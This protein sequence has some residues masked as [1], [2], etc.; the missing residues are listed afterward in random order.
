MTANFK[1]NQSGSKQKRLWFQ[2]L[3]G[4]LILVMLGV[5]L[6][7][8]IV[9]GLVTYSQSQPRLKAD[10]QDE[11]TRVSEIQRMAIE[12][13]LSGI[14]ENVR[15]VA[16]TERVRSM[17][18]QRAQSAVDGYAIDWPFYEGIYVLGPDGITIA[19]SKQTVLDLST[20]EYF[21]KAMQGEANISQPVISRV[22]GKMIVSV[23]VPVVQDGEIVGVAAGA[24]PIS[25]I[26]EL[27]QSSWVG[28]TGDA[29]LVNDQ[30]Y[31]ITPSRF[32]DQMIEEGLVD[33]DTMAISADVQ[34]EASFAD[35][36]EGAGEYVNFRGN[37][38]IGAYSRIESRGWG[39]I[40]EQDVS[41]ALVTANFIRNVLLVGGVI[42]AVIVAIIGI[43][44]A[45]Q[46]AN[47]I[48]A[49]TRTAQELSLGHI[50]Q[51]VKYRSK[52]EV[53][54]LAESFREMID[55]Q[56]L[57]AGSAAR[58]AEGDFTVE[59][60]PK[61]SQD[62]M[63][64]A[65]VN[66]IGSLSRALMRVLENARRLSQASNDM[67]NAAKQAETA[68]SQIATTIQQVARGSSI[69]SE[70]VGKTA[71][72][73]EEMGRAIDGVARGAQEQAV[74]IS[75]A[76]AITSKLTGAIQQVMGNAKSVMG[77]A[78]EAAQTA[79][80]SSSIVNE[81]V[82]GM[83]SIK[84][85]VGVSAQKVEEMGNRSEQIGMI[86][87]T[88]EDIASQTNLLALNAA[89]EAARAGEHGKGFAVVADEVRKLAERSASATREIA[90]LIK[91]I[92]KT[93][94]EAVSAMEEGSQ[95]VEKGVS[96]G[97][98]AGEALR[99]ILRAVEGVAEQAEEAV[100]AMDEMSGSANELV[101]AMDSVSAVVEENTA[102]TEQ[103]AAGAQEVTHA[104]ENIA[105]V[106]EENSA[107]IEEVS[108]S[109]EEMSAQVEEVTKSAQDLAEMAQQLKDEVARFKLKSKAA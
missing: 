22:S 75:K 52:D 32:I 54:D 93:V 39:L 26:S 108:A 99:T 61:D 95:E 17:D 94:D 78:T 14:M 50:D 87:E 3:K 24:V 105:S 9:V 45:Q 2:S 37:R 64:N 66:M 86:V 104:I 27:L 25:Y 89:I 11:F 10:V 29:Y 69:Q 76:S 16:N 51:E 5:S 53:G 44:F 80:Q 74:S 33:A 57:M 107:A 77:G 102:A 42:L 79:R 43:L 15:A 88:I 90:D 40:L 1:G 67:A 41:E 96:K 84:V 56:K 12:T 103:M 36:Q 72:S 97:A 100:A 35:R 20:R 46:I 106:S 38:V 59:V 63:G 70:G 8:L 71:S 83:Q 31:M 34:A 58:M 81:T 6:I 60:A 109:T 49:I 13:W 98:Q 4:K 73:V 65:F 91:G 82:Q 30:G 92:Q 68:T 19:N 47:P 101:T 85:K 48:A 18:P 21:Q 28:E 23:A 62:A 55:Y 7:P